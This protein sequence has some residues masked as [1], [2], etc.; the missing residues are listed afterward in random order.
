MVDAYEPLLTTVAGGME[1][2]KVWFVVGGIELIDI[3]INI[4]L[5]S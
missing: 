4:H 5:F 1:H 3:H 2:L